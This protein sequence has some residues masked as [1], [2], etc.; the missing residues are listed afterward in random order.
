MKNPLCKSCTGDFLL[1]NGKLREY[2]LEGRGPERE[3]YH[4][5]QRPGYKHYVVILI[6]EYNRVRQSAAEKPYFYHKLGA[7]L[8]GYNSADNLQGSVDYIKYSRNQSRLGFCQYSLFYNIRK[9]AAEAVL[10]HID[11]GIHYK[12]VYE[13]SA[14]HTLVLEVYVYV[15]LDV[16]VLTFTHFSSPNIS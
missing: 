1:N 13:K 11:D 14:A 8:I 10:R 7:Y 4:R 6:E 9:R 3:L 15:V 12:E 5:V 2:Y 16:Y